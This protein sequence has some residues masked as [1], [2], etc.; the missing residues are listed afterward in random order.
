LN[1]KRHKYGA[2]ATEVDGIKFPSK[3]EAELYLYY[4]LLQHGGKL[5]ILALQPVVHLTR[6]RIKMIPDFFIEENGETYWSEMKGMETPVWKIKLR[7]WKKYGPGKLKI[8]KKE[9]KRGIY[10]FKEVRVEK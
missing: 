6:A 4:K 3:A 10:L 9:R 2:S 7:L 8:Y 1:F 5:K